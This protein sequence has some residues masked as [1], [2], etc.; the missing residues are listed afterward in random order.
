LTLAP[1][2]PFDEV[3]KITGQSHIFDGDMAIWR[4]APFTPSRR[5]FPIY[6]KSSLIFG[7]QTPD[8]LQ[9]R[10]ACWAKGC[11]HARVPRTKKRLVGH[12]AGREE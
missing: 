8:D 11:P 4:L 10:E 12:R 7:L 5:Y 2:L 1:L 3:N 6:L 9:P